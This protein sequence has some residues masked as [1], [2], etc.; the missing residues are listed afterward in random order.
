MHSLS[1]CSAR[2]YGSS[3]PH[4]SQAHLKPSKTRVS[5]SST[6]WPTARF[7]LLRMSPEERGGKNVVDL[8]AGYISKNRCRFYSIIYASVVCIKEGL[9]YPPSRFVILHSE[10]SGGRRG[11]AGR[12][13]APTHAFQFAQ[14]LFGATSALPISG[15]VSPSCSRSHN[16]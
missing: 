5:I 6:S 11:E 15:H 10:R 13:T 12:S 2:A 14:Q 1:I 9:S 8:F 4:A 16:Q 7:R 3:K